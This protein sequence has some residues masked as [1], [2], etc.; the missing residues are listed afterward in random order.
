MTSVAGDANEFDE[1]DVTE[2]EF[3]RMHAASTPV[4]VDLVPRYYA[5]RLAVGELYT[6]TTVRQGFA[7]A[8][9]GHGQ[10]TV[11]E[12]ATATSAVPSLA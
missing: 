7:A 4:L 10:W 2:Q 5:Q 9:S 8:A 3:D 6:L 1:F 12:P 11:H